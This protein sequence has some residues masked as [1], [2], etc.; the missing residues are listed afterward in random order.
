MHIDALFA[1]VAAGTGACQN[2]M[3]AFISSR[4]KATREHKRKKY[5]PLSVFALLHGLNGW[6]A[7]C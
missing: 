5:E 3:L 7:S 2:A 4:A 1:G 6:Q